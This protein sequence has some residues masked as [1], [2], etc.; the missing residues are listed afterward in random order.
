MSCEV[1]GHHYADLSL[2]ADA[3]H[4]VK[5]LLVNGRQQTI[6]C[7]AHRLLLPWLLCKP[8]WT[9]RTGS[10]YNTPDLL[11]RL[12]EPLAAVNIVLVSQGSTLHMA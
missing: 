10:R 9:S 1:L 12:A 2:C 3:F 5:P 7:A 11:R 8:R 6:R 4:K